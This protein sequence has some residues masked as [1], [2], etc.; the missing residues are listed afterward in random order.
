MSSISALVSMIIKLEVDEG[1]LKY[2][3]DLHVFNDKKKKNRFF[4]LDL[5]CSLFFF[6]STDLLTLYQTI[7]AFKDLEEKPF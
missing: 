4:L 2:M 6:F 5:L 3:I 7:K 1:L